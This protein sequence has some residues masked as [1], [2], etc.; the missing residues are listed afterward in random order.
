MSAAVDRV[1]RKSTHVDN[2]AKKQKQKPTKQPKLTDK[3]TPPKAAQPKA[4]QP[5]AASVKKTIAPPAK[6]TAKKEKPFLGQDVIP[7]L[8]AIRDYPFVKPSFQQTEQ[9]ALFKQQKAD[10][11][12]SKSSLFAKPLHHLQKP[13]ASKS[14]I[15]Q[16]LAAK[17]KSTTHAS[18]KSKSRTQNASTSKTASQSGSQQQ[19]QE[20]VLTRVYSFPSKC[21]TPAQWKE[22][23]KATTL[24]PKES[25][26]NAR[27][28][29]W[30][31]KKKSAFNLWGEAAP[32]VCVP[33]Q[34]GLDHFGE[35]AQD[36]RP[37][38]LAIDVPFDAKLWGPTDP[39]DQQAV[40]AVAKMHFEQ[41]KRGG[42]IELPTSSGKTVLMIYI[43]C[44]L[45][46]LKA[47]VISPMVSLHSQL[48]RRIASFVPKAR[49]GIIHQQQFEVK[50]KD[51]VVGMLHTLA[52][53]EH[54][55]DAFD[56][57][58]VV[59]F[60]EVDRIATKHFSR[61][62][63]KLAHV[64]FIIGLS[65]TVERPDG[66]ERL[67]PL[68]LGP[69]I[70]RA[71]VATKDSAKTLVQILQYNE[72][73]TTTL[74]QR[75]DPTSPD[76]ARMLARLMA[77]E[78]RHAKILAVL[79]ALYAQKRN[80][81][82]LAQGVKYGERLVAD[83]QARNP[84]RPMIHYKACL[85]LDQREF[86]DD[87]VHNL[88]VATYSIFSVGMD[89]GYLDT[90]LLATP[91][92]TITQAVGRLRSFSKYER[93]PLLI[94]DLV[95]GFGFFLGQHAARKRIYRKRK[96]RFLD[97]IPLFGPANHLR[98]NQL[99]VAD[100]TLLTD[101]KPEKQNRNKSSQKISQKKHA[102]N[103]SCM[104]LRTTSTLKACEP[105]R[106][107]F[108]DLDLDKGDDVERDQSEG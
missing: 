53:Q 33:P 57:F 4:A 42:I 84:G 90:L 50:D 35:P 87:H 39:F 75:R 32:F 65:A 22:H 24:Q 96:Y 7:P 13:V 31:Q 44:V 107:I 106:D 3:P 19:M 91:R 29:N 61:V 85:S 18:N 23:K 47:L 78:M 97:D 49:I 79:D 100:Q 37:R 51:I 69:F 25:S 81:V 104:F 36:L 34:Y 8:S 15:G 20:S 95:D 59:I 41:N 62:L 68:F 27:K 76:A 2:E 1:K 10:L 98:L 80:V 86:V 72:G 88:I 14:H 92:R 67:F 58:G 94:L 45:L 74:F 48:S 66:M 6:K 71:P 56:D 16:G 64:R 30:K 5:K 55:S 46:K 101:A 108:F 60:D 12:C 38:G 54:A 17:K 73:A 70:F 99:G 93:Q 102:G 21:L 11:P 9:L 103:Q 77:D 40:A 89:V 26:F 43:I 52:G 28:S 83:S 105:T 63:Y 82:V